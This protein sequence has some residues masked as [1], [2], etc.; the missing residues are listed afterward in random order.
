MSDIQEVA[1]ESWDELLDE[2]GAQDV[3]FRRAYLESASL[4]GQGRPVYLHLRG[5]SGDVVLP[6]LVREAPDGFSDIGTPMGYGGP[7]ATGV[8]PP[9]AT[10]FDAYA[11]WCAENRVVA[12][13]ARFQPVL[14]NHRL[15][16]GRWHLE[17]IGHSIGWR[18][19][20][21]SAEDLVAGMDAHHRR[22]VRKAR[23]AE[24]DVRVE[25]APDELSAFVSLYEETMRRRS[26]SAFYFFPD[27]YWRHLTHELGGALVRADARL[28]GEV[29]ASIV[30]L[31]AP[32]LLHYHLGA[33]SERGQALGANHLLFSETAAWAAEQGFA[34]FHLGGGVGGFED[35][36]YEFKRR[37]DPDG[38]S[39][40]FWGRPCTMPTPTALSPEATRS[41]TRATS[42]PTVDR[43]DLALGG[44]RRAVI[45]KALFWAS[46]GALAWTHV[47]YPVAA[48]ALARVRPRPVRKDDVTPGVTVIVAA[49]DE[50]DVIARRVENL[51]E[52]D[53][54]VELLEIVVA[55]D[56]STDRT[57][58][59]VEEIA[60]KA[61]ERAPRVRLVRSERAGK[62]TA[63]NT[64][65]GEV[66][67]EVVAFSDAN[68]RWEPDAL[69]RLVR[70]FADPD[71]GYV[72]GQLRL[73]SPDGVNQEGLYW[74]YEL[75][76]RES[77]SA[78]GS[79]TAGN[80]AIYAVRRSDYL[81]WDDPRIGHDFG[82]P[83]RLVQRGRRAVYEPD[84]LAWEKPASNVEDEY[85]RK[86]R[87]MTRS[88]RPLLDGSLAR[89]ND[90]LFL[91][92]LV[93]HRVLRYGSGVLHVVLLGTSLALAGKGQ[94][95]RLALADQLG[96]LALA[97]AG[98]KR[99]R[100]PGAG[101]SYYYLLT[102]AAT[103]E[104]LV[105]YLREGSGDVGQGRGHPVKTVLFVG[106]GR[107]QRRAIL[108]RASSAIASSQSTATRTRS[109]SRRPTSASSST[110]P[111]SRASRRSAESSRWTECSPSLPIAPCRSS[112]RSRRHLACRESA[113]RPH[114]G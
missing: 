22:V 5:A 44:Y 90:P 85:G 27:A 43:A 72:C 24:I 82:L 31:A 59:I 25:T 17:Q 70:S 65:V 103:V 7:V 26:A 91:A 112:L 35:S 66:D 1:P 28:G 96:F 33:S 87:M 53:Y 99:L 29:V 100:V 92:E 15:A 3:Y 78:I 73:E 94:L 75:W 67:A 8:E 107:H 97:Y 47:G 19:E 40:P 9:V 49:H 48:A 61:A 16:E 39:P 50:E 45:L 105:R 13:F 84:A 57:D 23:A 68:S 108:R 109:V 11:R 4:L 6:C 98:R 30:C 36:L 106:G 21:R 41:T 55:S 20:G 37:F 114:T 2:I 80:G 64:A 110:S 56:G 54:P 34:C 14:E 63:Q 77:E 52:L 12:T 76:Q 89:T 18:V 113:S 101:L 81:G 102:T 62:A 74:R 71:V 88:W 83:F 60:Q 104:A 93:S 38:R 58:E 51:L 79:I 42:R 95:Y 10:F 86:V 32:P 46:A 69:R 111:T